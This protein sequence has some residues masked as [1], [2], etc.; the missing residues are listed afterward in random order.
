M[1]TIE[2]YKEIYARYQASHLSAQDFC[3]NEGITR[4][5]FYYWQKKY[6]KSQKRSSILPSQ[7]EVVDH[8]VKPQFIP[9]AISSITSG[10]QNIPVAVKAKEKKHPVSTPCVRDS[11][12]EIHYPGGTRVRLQ[13]SLDIELI[14]TLIQISF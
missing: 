14:K 10:K 12:I 6:R 3:K 7:P 2:S 9:V 8:A 5:R 13:G 4:S 11:L 1:W